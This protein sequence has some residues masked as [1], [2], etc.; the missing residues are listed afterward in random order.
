MSDCTIYTKTVCKLCDKVKLKLKQAGVEFEIINLDLPE[1]A[2]ARS[3]VENVI[4]ARSVPV[5]VSD[6]LPPILGYRPE[7]LKQLISALTKNG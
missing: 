3:Y 7:K 6:V 2:E 5:V 4:G 1:F